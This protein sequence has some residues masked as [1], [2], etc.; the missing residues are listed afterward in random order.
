MQEKSIS[1]QALISD[2]VM[3]AA[4]VLG[5]FASIAIAQQFG[6][7]GLALGG[8]GLISAIGLGVWMLSPGS[9][10][11]RLTFA[12]AL[13]AMVAL[14]IDLGRGTIE[15][16][17]GVFVVLGLLLMYSDWRPI[18]LAAAAVAVEHLV[19]DRLQAAGMGVFCTTSP[20]ILKVVMH[21][22]Y[23]ILQT[24]AEI[25]MAVWMSR[26]A[27]QGTASAA[28]LTDTL[29]RVRE[30]LAT[31][32][33]SAAKIESASSEIASGNAELSQRTAQSASQLQRAASSM[34]QLTSTVRSSAESAVGANRLAASAA[35]VAE[36]GGEVVREAVSKMEDIT[37]SSRRIADIIGVIDGI[38]FQTNILALN[39][40]V[41]AARA[42]EQ[43]RGFAV[44]ATEV[45]SL[46]QRSATAARE[47]KSLIHASVENV[48][49]GSR[50]VNEA[51]ETM[52]EVVSGIR[53]VAGIIDEISRS[54]TAQS[55]GIVSMHDT[56]SDLDQMT[57]QNTA[58]VEQSSAA[59]ESLRVQA[60]RLT[61]VVSSF[62]LDR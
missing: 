39:A 38:A 44:V 21:A 56:V 16:H 37:S 19:T 58:L 14:H 12:L 40:A 30:A 55:A 15:F 53:S 29:D 34:E 22:L 54:A 59:A 48:D 2:R 49:S 41:E 43:G 24:G 20:S 18:L 47:I 31:T 6:E 26:A 3:A 35:K 28:T 46:A 5:A 57:R 61:A 11:S 51:G 25:Y 62:S 23:V 50:L 32:R 52:Q 7:M 45:R 4:L 10:L 13:T 9:L 8:A 27:A 42:G 17:F 1:S 33:E 36:H 60:G